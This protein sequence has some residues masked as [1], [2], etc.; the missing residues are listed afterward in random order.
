MGGNP[1]ELLQKLITFNRNGM[2]KETFHKLTKYID[3]DNFTSDQMAKVSRACASLVQWVCAVYDYNTIIHAEVA[4]KEQVARAALFDRPE[5]EEASAASEA[6]Q[7]ALHCLTKADITEVKALNKPPHGV[8]LTMEFVCTIFNITPRNKKENVWDCAK[9]MVGDVNFLKN[10]MKY[11]CRG[12]TVATYEK[13]L[14][15]MSNP[16]FTVDNIKRASFACASLCQWGHAI[17]Q[18]AAIAHELGLLNESAPINESGE[19]VAVEK[20]ETAD[21]K[22][23]RFQLERAQNLQ[24][25]INCTRELKS[26]AKPPGAASSLAK[27]IGYLLEPEREEE[28]GWREAQREMANPRHFIAKLNKIDLTSYSAEH[29]RKIMVLLEE[30]DMVFDHMKNK[31]FS[32]ATIVD[33]I[34]NMIASAENV[35]VESDL[36]YLRMADVEID[37]TDE[38]LPSPATPEEKNCSLQ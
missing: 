27:L 3:N 23:Q 14:P 24:K 10:V 1:R 21:E 4:T 35:S 18:Y 13:A 30:E 25:Q 5:F 28:F 17:M 37:V 7:Q 19:K 34:R 38:T 16:D 31:S 26:L 11:D 29:L 32:A 9:K 15:F 20:E 36:V 33:S 6:V 12:M 22:E 2:S 8:L